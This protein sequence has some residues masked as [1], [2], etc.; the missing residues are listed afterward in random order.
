MIYDAKKNWEADIKK[1]Q[2]VFPAQGL[3][4]IIRG[5]YPELTPIIKGGLVLDS[6]CGDGRNAIFLKGEGFQVTGLE[7][8]QTIC[9]ELTAR[10]P[11]IDFQVGESSN[12]PFSD[13]TFDLTLSWHAIY[14]VSL[15]VQDVVRN[16]QEVFRV[17]KKDECSRFI[18]SIPMPTSFIY[19][20]S[21]L[22]N[23]KNGIEYRIIRNDPFDIRNG[24]I[25]GCFPSIEVLSQIM[26]QCGFTD[27]EIGEEKGWWF[28]HQY[29]WWVV[30]AKLI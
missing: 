7:I 28:G 15:G 5:S 1:S 25:L 29:D 11:G 10:I 23:I 27:L 26:I 14:Y 22:I 18:V 24:E 16:F 6:G 9:E 2:D 13:N 4:R 8:T 17:T 21:E 20:D 12:L 19:K 30:V 3:I